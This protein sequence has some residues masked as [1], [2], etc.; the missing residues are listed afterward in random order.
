VLKRLWS[1]RS[2][3]W[4]LTIKEYQLRFRQTGL[5]FAWAVIPP[6]VTLG[7]A[8]VVFHKVAGIQTAGVPYAVFALSALAPWTL[9]ANSITQGVPSILQTPGIVSK[10]AFPRAVLPLAMIGISLLDLA[11]TSLLFLAFAYFM[12]HGLTLTAVWF[13]LLLLIE[14][15][16]AV[17]IVLWGSALNVFARDI[18]LMVPL[19]VQLWLL[20][21]PVLYPL[22]AVPSGLR[23]WYVLNPMTGLAES[24]RRVLILGHPPDF[25]LLMPSIVGSVVLVVVGAWYFAVTER[26]F[27]D[28]L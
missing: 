27:A 23:R 8:T 16:L 24:F 1:F 13:P 19:L 14:I 9:L 15:V 26:R 4:L 11:A 5:G 28:V 22:K 25:A 6:L 7:G 3:I 18:A 20:V 10:F 17:G 21:T 12:G 2:L